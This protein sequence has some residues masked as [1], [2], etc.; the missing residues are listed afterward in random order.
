MPNL[1]TFQKYFFSSSLLLSLASCSNHTPH[2]KIANEEEPSAE[3]IRLADKILKKWSSTKLPAY[4]EGKKGDET[5]YH[6]NLKYTDMELLK[7]LHVADQKVD[8]RKTSSLV[9]WK[10]YSSLQHQLAL[11]KLPALLKLGEIRPNASEEHN[12]QFGAY[13]ELHLYATP[14]P[15]EWGDA[16]LHFS[17][18]LL[19]RKDYHVSP[20]W[21]YG[22]Y[23]PLSASPLVNLARTNFYVETFLKNEG[24]KNEFV[25][26]KPVS[27][28]KYLVKIVVPT[29]KK[30][31]FIANLKSLKIKCPSEKGW[32]KLISEQHMPEKKDEDVNPSNG[33]DDDL[34]RPVKG[35]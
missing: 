6:Y 31:S 26:H 11:E 3:Q 20:A 35:E 9:D 22:T 1:K 7:G 29:G 14:R 4:L 28:K 13:F 16:E 2:R 23:G 5:V 25:F 18:T 27:F 10:V 32:E 19:D 30:T 24:Y 21:D 15:F 17:E 33:E 34:Y 8:K 12:S